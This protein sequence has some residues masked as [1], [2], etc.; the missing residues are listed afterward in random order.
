MQITKYAH[1]CVRVAVNGSTILIDPGIWTEAEAFDGVDA[2]L[3]THEHGDHVDVPRLAG[4]GVPVYAPAEAAIHGLDVVPIPRGS[5]FS[6]A[7]V[8][9][10][11]IGDRHGFTYQNRPDVANLGYLVDERLYHP[12]DALA[13]PDAPVETLLAPISGPW[14]RLDEAIEFVRTVR[15]ERTVAIHDAM[16][17]ERGLA[18]TNGWF[19]REAGA[20][21]RWLAPGEVV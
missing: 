16:L 9:V 1:A 18:I 4:L 15:P 6:V 19:E 5:T 14:L 7:G 3:V 20:G 21:Y 8:R 11:A 13:P 17:N 2:V 10:R 12:G